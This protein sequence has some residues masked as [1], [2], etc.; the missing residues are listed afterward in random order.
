MDYKDRC[1]YLEER[2]KQLNEIGIALSKE[3]DFN[4]LFEMIMEE[5]RQITNADGRTL[6]MKSEDGKSLEFEIVRNDSL[7]LIMGGTSDNDIPWS[8]LSLYDESGNPSHKNDRYRSIELKQFIPLFK[9]PDCEFYSLQV[10]E[11]VSEL[12]IIDKE[13]S[14]VDLGEKFADFSDTASALSQLDLLISVDTSVAHLAGALAKPVWNLLPANP[15]W[16]WLLDREETPWYPTMRLFRQKE[17][18]QWDDVIE[19]IRLELANLSLTFRR[20]ES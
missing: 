12:R 6:Y 10:G 8:S 20:F 1:K 13:R 15:D 14:I 3:N 16:R 7:K 4:K 11:R 9:I 19:K 5:A 2:I 17:L 18:G